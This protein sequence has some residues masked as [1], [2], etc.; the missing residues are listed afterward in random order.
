MATQIISSGAASY[1]LW[2]GRGSQGG[3]ALAVFMT[4]SGVVAYEDCDG[5]PTQI[6]SAQ[7]ATTILGSGGTL[8]YVDACMD[9][10]G[11]IIHVVAYGTGGA[12]RAVAYNTITNSGGWSWG[13]WSTIV[14]ALTNNPTTYFNAQIVCNSDGDLDVIYIDGIKYHGT[15][16][17]QLIHTRNTG[18]G[19]STPTQITPDDGSTYFLPKLSHDHNSNNMTLLM[20]SNATTYIR[21]IQWND[22][23]EAWGS[24]TGQSTTYNVPRPIRAMVVN[25]SNA[26][27]YSDN[28]PRTLERSGTDS[29]YVITPPGIINGDVFVQDSSFDE[30]VFVRNS[31]FN[32][33][34]VVYD[35]SFTRTVDVENLT[36]DMLGIVVGWERTIPHQSSIDYL[37]RTN[38]GEIYWGTY[39][40]STPSVSAPH[41]TL[42]RPLLARQDCRIRR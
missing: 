11:A 15:T 10:G 34:V 13:T 9:D 1:G 5:T 41:P 33:D 30:Y 40:L 39:T 14:A 25:S 42:A 18:A 24:L 7:S 29:T 32:M 6:G 21:Y 28:T 8:N 16:M 22:S 37:I 26:R 36:N 17:E 2:C 4:T 3:D 23:T 12:T 35:G 27:Y 20:E 31:S 38:G 19:W